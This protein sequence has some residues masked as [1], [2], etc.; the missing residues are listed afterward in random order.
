MLD[1]ICMGFAD[2]WGTGRGRKIPNEKMPPA[3]FKSHIKSNRCIERN[4]FIE[5]GG[6]VKT[7]FLEVHTSCIID[8]GAIT[9]GMCIDHCI[10][11][12][13]ETVRKLFIHPIRRM[14]LFILV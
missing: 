5:D 4:P 2:L 14:L 3:G 1:Y 6:V 11:F 8:H 12:L 9:H 13:F 10:F 7:E